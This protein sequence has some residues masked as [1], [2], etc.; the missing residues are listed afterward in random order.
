MNRKI[1]IAISVVIVAVITTIFYLEE[2]EHEPIQVN[3][4]TFDSMPPANQT[5]SSITVTTDKSSYSM[6]DAIVISGKVKPSIAGTQVTILILDPNNLL[7]QA[8]RISVSTD[9][10]FQTTIM[11]T[12]ASW[13]L[14][15]TYSISVQY[16]S[17]D[18]K[19]QKAFYFS[20]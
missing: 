14:D 19:A 4:S 11:T 13:K 6:G 2:D 18:V 7:L 15:G 1:P 5:T 8:E 17:S 3:N 16:G 10:I 9:G 12:P 20:G